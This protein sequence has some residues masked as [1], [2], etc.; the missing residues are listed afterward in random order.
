VKHPG[1][2]S[3]GSLVAPASQSLLRIESAAPAEPDVGRLDRF[4]IAPID[5]SDGSEWQ[6][7]WSQGAAGSGA[8][9]FDAIDAGTW[10]IMGS[11]SGVAA[12]SKDVRLPTGGKSSDPVVVELVPAATLR[13]RMPPWI[14]L[15]SVLQ[16]RCV[17]SSQLQ[18]VESVT[19]ARRACVA[20]PRGAYS[21]RVWY[22]SGAFLETTVEVDE[23]EASAVLG[24]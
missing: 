9:E 17:G 8:C 10:R 16:V 12:K 5:Q 14:P 24:A 3:F 18:W 2:C 15:G 20:V 21:V 22:R 23:G 6:A 7:R 11:G 19:E 13:I 1:V 4:A